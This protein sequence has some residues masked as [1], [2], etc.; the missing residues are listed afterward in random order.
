M[1]KVIILIILAIMLVNTNTCFAFDKWT[2]QEKQRQIIL[3]ILH[4]TDY[5]QTCEIVKNDKYYEMNPILGRHPSMEQLNYYAIS[6]LLLKTAITHVLPHKYRKYAQCVFIGL[7][8]GAVLNN[9]S[10]GI[11]IGF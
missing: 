2:K 11:R 5:F 9:Y 6:S 8:G 3:T 7:S 10:I 4:C 1:K